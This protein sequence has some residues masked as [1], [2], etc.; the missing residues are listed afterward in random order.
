MSEPKNASNESSNESSKVC[1]NDSSND[2]LNVGVGSIESR[3]ENRAANIVTSAEV[4]ALPPYPGVPEQHIFYVQTSDD[5]AQAEHA[6]QSADVLGFDTE[7]K[8]VFIKGQE[9]DGPHLLQLATDTQAYL[10]PL[11]TQEQIDLSHDLV[12]AILESHQIIKVGFGL[13][14]DNQRLLAK[15]G[16]KVSNVLDLSR[17]MGE[18]KKKQMG[19]K[20]G[21]AKF[22]GQN[23]LK[24]KR[25]STSNWSSLVLNSR[26]RKYA[27][28]D[29]HSAL[30]LYRA[31][32]KKA[33]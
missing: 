17:L 29:A 25:I 3:N 23:L 21:V 15:L 16:V 30:M 19:A 8:P 28:D 31:W 12:R 22:F 27:A 32:L 20:A 5:L 33:K 6:L 18:S 2:S 24:S 9:S 13:G 1:S 26:Q 10:F 4:D 7:S 11:I 14:D